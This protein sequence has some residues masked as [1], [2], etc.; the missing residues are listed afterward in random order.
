M[1]SILNI[2]YKKSLVKI[3]HYQIVQKLAPKFSR[4][5]TIKHDYMNICSFQNFWWQEKGPDV[6]I[7]LSKND[8]GHSPKQQCFSTEVKKQLHKQK[9][10]HLGHARPR[11]IRNMDEPFL[12]T[13]DSAWHISIQ[14]NYTNVIESIPVGTQP[15]VRPV[16][17]L[18]REG[19]LNPPT[20]VQLL[21]QQRK[22][23]G[24]ILVASWET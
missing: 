12:T 4:F 23:Q 7:T 5:C 14:Q 16:F 9:A 8:T 3:K 15:V 21:C 24:S 11:S 18:G 13:F 1:T 10:L 6:S 19:Y 20:C 17:K 2:N 22:I